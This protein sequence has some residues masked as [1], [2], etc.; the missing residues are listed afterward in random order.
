MNSSLD[1]LDVVLICLV[2][3]KLTGAADISWLAVFSPI[4]F[5]LLFIAFLALLASIFG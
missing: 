5:P 4:W 3:I 1:T 2:V